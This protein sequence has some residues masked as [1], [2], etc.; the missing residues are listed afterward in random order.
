MNTNSVYPMRLNGEPVAT[1]EST[2]P[3]GFP[4]SEANF[5]ACL[6]KGF[7]A[8]KPLIGRI[9]IAWRKQIRHMRRAASSLAARP[10]F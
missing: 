5:S 4:L 1:P 7:F 8:P 10:F 3:C 6:P 9:R 2:S